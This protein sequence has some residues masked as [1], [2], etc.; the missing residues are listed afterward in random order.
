MFVGINIYV[1]VNAMTTLRNKGF[2]LNLWKTKQKPAKTGQGGTQPNL[3][4]AAIRPDSDGNLTCF[5]KP[6]RIL[7]V[8]TRGQTELI[9]HPS[10]GLPFR[11]TV[12]SINYP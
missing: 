8:I 1:G 6:Y 7:P 10:L 4:V 3:P 12:A 11:L 5:G 2:S 9:Q